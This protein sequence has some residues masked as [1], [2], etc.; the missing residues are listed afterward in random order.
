MTAA[1]HTPGFDDTDAYFEEKTAEWLRAGCR[2]VVIVDPKTKTVRIHRSSGGVDVTDAIA[3]ED[4]L[5]GWK[6]PL[7][8][9]FE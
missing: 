3:V 9:V 1:E 2:A 5:P 4:V 6:L 7:G 8:E